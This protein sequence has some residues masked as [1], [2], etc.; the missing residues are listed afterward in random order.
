MKKNVVLLGVLVLSQGA[1]AGMLKGTAQELNAIAAGICSTHSYQDRKA[2]DANKGFFTVHKWNTVVSKNE[3]TLTGECSAK[4][5]RDASGNLVVNAGQAIDLQLKLEKDKDHVVTTAELSGSVGEQNI[6]SE[7]TFGKTYYS[8][9]LYAMVSSSTLD[10]VSIGQ[11]I[12]DIFKSGKYGYKLS[13]E[14][15][16][17]PAADNYTGTSLNFDSTESWGDRLLKVKVQQSNYKDALLV[18]TANIMA[19]SDLEFA[20]QTEVAN[21]TF[22]TPEGTNKTLGCSNMVFSQSGVPLSMLT[23]AK[24]LEILEVLKMR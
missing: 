15:T 16:V 2:A 13:R 12:M 18:K 23:P 10:S 20:F 3:V 22:I 6:K 17:W 8:A 11:S 5:V 9:N 1:L 24:C 21:S 4:V 14:S 7:F 19:M